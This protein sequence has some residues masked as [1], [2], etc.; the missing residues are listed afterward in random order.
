MLLA[1]VCLCFQIHVA[2]TNTSKKKKGKQVE[3]RQ[4][5]IRFLRSIN[6][7]R[8]KKLTDASDLVL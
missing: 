8:N 2:Q 1:C 6:Y 3:C 7:N 4:T 5:K